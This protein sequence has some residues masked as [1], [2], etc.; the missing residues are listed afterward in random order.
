MSAKLVSSSFKSTLNDFQVGEFERRLDALLA[1]LQNSVPGQHKYQPM[2]SSTNYQQNYGGT[3]GYGSVRPKQTSVSPIYQEHYTMTET[4]K[5]ASPAFNGSSGAAAAPP[6]QY[7]HQYHHQYQ[8]QGATPKIHNNGLYGTANRGAASTSVSN[9]KNIC[10]LDNLLHDL[11]NGR[12]D[13][14]LERKEAAM[15]VAYGIS[16]VKQQP[17]SNYSTLTGT[18]KRPTVDSLLDELT[19]ASTNSI[20]A[21]PNGSVNTAAKSPTPGRH[22]TI[23]VRETTTEKLTGPEGAP[24]ASLE[25]QIVH[26]K[27]SYA[28]PP[29]MGAAAAPPTTMFAS[30]ATKELDD[31][32]ASL[33]DFKVASGSNHHQAVVTDYAKPNKGI[34]HLT[35]TEITETSTIVEDLHHHP[36]H[37]VGGDNLESMLGSLQANMSRQGVNTVQK[38]C[39]NAC[40]KPIVGQVITALGKTWHPEHFTCN[41]CSQELGTRNFFEREGFPYCEP[42]YHN[43]FS[44]RCAYCNGAILD[45][46]VTALDKTWHTEHFFCAQCGQQF[47]EDGFHERDGKP[48]CR[49]DYYEMFAPKCN[50]C[51]RAIMEN[52]ISALNSQWHPDCFVC[53]DCRRPFQGGSFFDHEGLP[54]CETHY[55]AKRGSLCAGCSKPITGRCIT[56][57]FKKFHPEHFVCAFCLKQLNKGTFKEQNEKPYCHACFDKIFG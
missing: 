38:G 57:M 16:Q 9:S 39:C 6:N 22:V 48:Y 23:T 24:V 42:D 29:Q 14:T 37:I 53:R 45:K 20:Y 3:P 26:K 33:S 47:G 56:A 15:P 8:H 32:M 43:L 51:N 5:S 31:L 44:P 11:S 12:Y 25:E 19:N 2:A 4:R 1:D 46:C 36:T 52:Y 54:Y 30:S 55:H 34:S 50:G 7:H 49:T 10:E 13:S 27:D 18:T 17:G 21:V 28:P 41:H 35:Q 40:E